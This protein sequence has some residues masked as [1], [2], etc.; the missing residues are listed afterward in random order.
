M[1]G[2]AGEVILTLE[3]GDGGDSVEGLVDF[4]L[5]GRSHARFETLQFTEGG[6]VEA[7]EEPVGDEYRSQNA[8]DDWGAAAKDSDSGD[9]GPEASD[10]LEDLGHEA[11]IDGFHILGETVDNATSRV[12]MEPSHWSTDD[13]GESLVVE[14]AGSSEHTE[15]DEDVEDDHQQRGGDTNAVVDAKPEFNLLVELVRGPPCEPL[16]HHDST[17]LLGGNGED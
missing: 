7:K 17:G 13:T 2:T 5:E 16:V 8:K 1:S 14:G 15:E 10:G 12:S 4:G 6:T 11:L 3:G 9:Q